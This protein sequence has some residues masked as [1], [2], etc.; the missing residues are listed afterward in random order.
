MLQKRF[1]LGK[2]C[3][4]MEE[5]FKC[6]SAGFPNQLIGFQKVGENTATGK[7]IWKLLDKDGNEHQHK[8]RSD[9]QLQQQQHGPNNNSFR[10]KDS[11]RKC[12]YCDQ[13][14]TFHNHI[15]A[16]SGKKI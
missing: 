4:K 2:R 8:L 16:P 10:A 13:D 5:C 11:V 15:K 6:K 7:N 1:D 9:S 12:W 14:I 3:K